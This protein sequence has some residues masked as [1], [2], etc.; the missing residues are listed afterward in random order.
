MGV[1]IVG[2]IRNPHGAASACPLKLL[3]RGGSTIR[4]SRNSG[5]GAGSPP[6]APRET[7][8]AADDED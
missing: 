6:P 7:E 1:Q 4:T 2:K 5:A 8:E 3:G